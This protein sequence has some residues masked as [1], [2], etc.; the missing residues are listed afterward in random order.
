MQMWAGESLKL[1]KLAE[2]RKN[3]PPHLPL[4]LLL[5]S[6]PPCSIVCGVRLCECV[7]VSE[8]VICSCS[9][10][11]STTPLS[12]ASW[13]PMTVLV[14]CRSVVNDN[15]E[16]LIRDDDGEADDRTSTM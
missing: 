10:A 6:S 11:L 14:P 5:A 8:G 7:A 3:P 12:G 1:F 13:P 2:F 16:G 9:I 4:S 15:A